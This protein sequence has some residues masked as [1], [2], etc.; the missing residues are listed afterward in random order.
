MHAIAETDDLA[1][2]IGPMTE[3]LEDARH[4]L[5]AGLGPPL[6]VGFGNIAGCVRVFDEA[7][8]CFWMSQGLSKRL[9]SSKRVAH[10]FALKQRR[11]VQNA[12]SIGVAG[13]LQHNPPVTVFASDA[14]PIKVLQQGDGVF[15]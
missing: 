6:V 2:K 8:L 10:D 13:R 15:S 5:S 9:R 14:L 12:F 1:Q 4:L 11:V 3:A 7:D